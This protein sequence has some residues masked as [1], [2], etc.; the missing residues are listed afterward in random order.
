MNWDHVRI[1]AET[2]EIVSV[3]GTHLGMRSEDSKGSRY[4]VNLSAIAGDPIQLESFMSNGPST[5]V[6]IATTN[7]SGAVQVN[8]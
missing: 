1:I 8:V 6:P 2:N 7:G 3:D 5:S 4:I